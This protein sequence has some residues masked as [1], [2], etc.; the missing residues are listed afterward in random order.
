[1]PST[2]SN[3]PPPLKPGE[4]VAARLKQGISI[5]RV[6]ETKDEFITIALGRNKQG[7]VPAER[8]AFVTGITAATEEAVE[9]LRAE[10]QSEASGLDLTELW[11][12]VRDEAEVLGLAELAGLLWSEKPAATRLL[13]LLIHLEE[14]SIYFETVNGGY[15]PKTQAELDEMHAKQRREGAR[16]EAKSSLMEALSDG[17]LPSPMN[18][19]HR[20]LLA[21]LRTF[22]IHGDSYAR[23][24]VAKGLLEYAGRVGRD[25]QRQAYEMLE[26]A[27]VVSLDEPLELER[28]DIP[29]VF[30]PEAL[31]E[32]AALPADVTGERADLTGL[33]AFTID[34]A[35]TVDRDDAF[36][37]ETLQDGYG[38]GIH[39]TDAAALV[40]M[41]TAL[42]AEADRRMA[43]LYLPELRVP[44]LPPDVEERLG[45]ID[46]DQTRGSLSM[47]LE[48]GEDGTVRG[49]RLTPSRIRSR[50]AYAYEDVDRVLSDA[51]HPGHA[52]LSTLHRLAGKLREQRVARG[53]A[54]LEHPEMGVHAPSPDDIS[55]TVVQ[56]SSPGR[57]L[58]SEFMILYNALTGKFC[59]DNKL[60]AP[61]RTQR[62]PQLT[63]ADGRPALPPDMAEGPYKHY[64]LTKR[65]A[66]AELSAQPGPHAG[67][68]VEAYTQ[69]SSPLRRYADLAVQRQVKH[70]LDTGAAL[71]SAEAVTSIAGRA[72]VQTRELG[73][74]E[75]DRKRYWF[76]KYLSKKFLD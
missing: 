54:V 48:M 46:P 19:H 15:R 18:E 6:L 57:L 31:A 37:I 12:T 52:V 61:F 24:E 22:V 38:V 64:L 76:L 43:T 50:R 68:G 75:E 67:L 44:M 27:G 17:R 71:Y 65:F 14:A 16:A 4:V 10:A 28:L 5:V 21:H 9:R 3:T 35:T 36:S 74:I 70:F 59:V 53:A 29:R 39:I 72:D 1:M 20:A 55:V 45:S 73:A 47:L 56:R 49:W 11:L 40:A 25:P 42:D 34:E 69:A 30:P 63:E 13:G 2:P 8:V 41:G 7:R 58:V 51:S 26:A 23:R 66:P 60:P 33:D 62:P 32:A